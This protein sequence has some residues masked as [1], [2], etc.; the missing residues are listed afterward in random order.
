MAGLSEPFAPRRVPKL[1]P[2]KML[3]EWERNGRWE[4]S[5]DEKLVAPYR[6]EAERILMLSPVNV[7]YP[8]NML[9]RV[10]ISYPDK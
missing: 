6:H 8:P 3:I 7:Y 5:T 4:G 10:R 9:N 1:R 2:E